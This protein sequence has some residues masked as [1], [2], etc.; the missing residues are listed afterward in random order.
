MIGGTFPYPDEVFEKEF[1]TL[2][3]YD[4]TEGMTGREFVQGL[5]R[6]AGLITVATEPEC[7]GGDAKMK[8]I[9]SSVA[10]YVL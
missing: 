2:S 4:R 3:T 10:K 1:L 8:Q 6:K 7:C 5:A 9:L